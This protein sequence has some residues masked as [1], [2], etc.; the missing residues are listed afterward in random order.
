VPG[1]ADADPVVSRLRA[2]ISEQDRAILQAVNRRLELV[3]E[4]KSRK[5][6]TGASYVDT[7]R[8]RALLDALVAE[9]AGPLSANGVA[10]LFRLV[11]ALGKREVYGL[12]P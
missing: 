4:L 7:T 8:E 6:A 11:I 1:Q 5:D 9:N 10:E 3:A 2:A 12:D